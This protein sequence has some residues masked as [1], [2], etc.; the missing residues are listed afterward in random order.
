MMNK[1]KDS[2]LGKHFQWRKLHVQII[3]KEY[4]FSIRYS[5]KIRFISIEWEGCNLTKWCVFKPRHTALYASTIQ[6]SLLGQ[7]SSLSQEI[8]IHCGETYSVHRLAW[9]YLNFFVEI[10]NK[11]GPDWQNYVVCL[12]R[13]RGHVFHIYDERAEKKTYAHRQ[14]FFSFT[15]EKKKNSM[16][17]YF[18][19][20]ILILDLSIILNTRKIFISFI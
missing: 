17:N 1:K 3:G 12:Q 14:L 18:T 5:G 20:S 2:I 13:S 6:R 8:P 7:K 4:D 10:S 16:I 15:Q 19:I 11:Y 9:L